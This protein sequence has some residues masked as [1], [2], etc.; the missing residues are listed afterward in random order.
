[1]RRLWRLLD[2]NFGERGFFGGHFSQRGFFLR[3]DCNVR[4]NRR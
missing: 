1:M 2:D 3:N 4:C